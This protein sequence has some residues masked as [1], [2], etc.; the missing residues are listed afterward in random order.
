LIYFGDQLEYAVEGLI[1]WDALQRE[2]GIIVNVDFCLRTTGVDYPEDE[3]SDVSD[4]VTFSTTWSNLDDADETLDPYQEREIKMSKTRKQVIKAV[5]N[6]Q[7][8]IELE[9][10]NDVVCG[11]GVFDTFL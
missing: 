1:P 10:R 6:G 11:E 9:K 7:K 8:A 5:L 2:P 3:Y 4:T